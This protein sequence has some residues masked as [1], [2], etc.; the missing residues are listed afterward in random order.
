MNSL[1]T[2]MFGILG[3]GVAILT[4]CSTGPA[5]A[6]PPT[7]K[8]VVTASNPLEGYRLG[9]GDEIKVT[10]YDEKDL[11]GP[12]VVDGLG[13]ISMSLIGAVE[14]KNLTLGE[15]Q[16]LI[17][18]KL[19]NGY[20]TDP[21]VTVEMTKGRPYYILGEVNRA[22]EYPFTSGLTVL[23]AIAVAGDF[24]YRAEK[25]KIMIT[26]S[27]GVERE[28]TLTSTTLVQPGD[29]IRIKERFF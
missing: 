5:M 1:R 28:V 15:A 10:V 25:K 29:R 19:K 2:A 22:G 17:E 13:Q 11:S 24:T 6:D 9:S 21:K 7:A 3:I 14:V 16:K 8:P 12:F 20:L 26:S 27:D 18:T 4:A 23:N